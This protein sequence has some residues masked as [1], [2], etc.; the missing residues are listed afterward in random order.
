MPEE[1]QCLLDRIQKDGVEK[2]ENEAASIVS[3]AEEKAAA[4]IGKANED[5]TTALA[6]AEKSAAVFAERGGKALEQAARD[7]VISV[8]DAVHAALHAVVNSEVTRTLDTETVAGMLTE[9]A[10]AY[11]SSPSGEA[12]LDILVNPA[13]QEKLVQHLSAE[14][15]EALRNGLDIKG[16]DSVI[17]GFRV[18]VVDSSVEHDFTAEAIT[19][20]LCRLVRPHLVEILRKAQGTD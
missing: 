7:V 19:E 6:E 9:V 14:F 18:S 11:F 8:Q 16:S 5:A 20:A 1:L 10:R 13:R 3:R 4:I 2:A 15:G 17:S 12:R